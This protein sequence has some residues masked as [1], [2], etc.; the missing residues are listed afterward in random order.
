MLAPPPAAF[1][2]TPAPPPPLLISLPGRTPK[3]R[4]FKARRHRNCTRQHKLMAEC[5]LNKALVQGA[6][7]SVAPPQCPRDYFVRPTKE[8]KQSF[9]Y[10]CSFGKFNGALSAVVDAAPQEKQNAAIYY[11]LLANS[12]AEQ[13]V[14]PATYTYIAIQ[15]PVK[16]H[17]HRASQTSTARGEV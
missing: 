7:S 3:M 15:I 11:Q 13:V 12:E 2:F 6:P 16:H 14:C 5:N 4:T 8:Q 10:V 17:D 9:S 1:P